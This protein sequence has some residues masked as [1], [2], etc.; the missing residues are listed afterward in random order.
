[1]TAREPRCVWCWAYVYGRTVHCVCCAALCCLDC[2]P[3]HPCEAGA[4]RPAP[5]IETEVNLIDY[6]IER[7]LER[8]RAA[9]DVELS[10]MFG[11]IQ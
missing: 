6:V 9:E 10:R 2:W 8:R 3:T 1:M 11:V 5:R 4:A 7:E